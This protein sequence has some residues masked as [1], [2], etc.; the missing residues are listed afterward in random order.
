M[1]R[2]IQD[3]RV[4]GLCPLLRFLK[5]RRVWENGSFRPSGKRVGRHIFACARQRPISVTQLYYNYLY[6]GLHIIQI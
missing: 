5:A 4:S 6:G 3:Y 1:I 2:Y